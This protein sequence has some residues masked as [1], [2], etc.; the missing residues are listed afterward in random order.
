[1]EL[2]EK[3]QDAEARSI[4]SSREGRMETSPGQVGL[5]K[6]LARYIHPFICLKL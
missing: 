4:H 3:V 1:M 6:Y 5:C 2:R